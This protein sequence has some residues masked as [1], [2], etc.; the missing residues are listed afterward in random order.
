MTNHPDNDRAPEREGRSTVDYRIDELARASGVTVRNIRYYQDRGILPPPRRDGRVGIYDDAHLARL[1]LITRLLERNYTAANITELLAAWERGRDLSDVLGLERAVSGN[2]DTEVPGLLTHTELRVLLG[3]DPAPLP[4]QPRPAAD[5]RGTD[6]SGEV[7]GID[8][9]EEVIAQAVRRGLVDPTSPKAGLGADYRVPSPRLLHA[10]EGLVAAGA[11][12]EAAV[13]LV[14]RMNA[15]LDDAVHNF[16][17][18]VAAGVLAG[19]EQD[20]M[21]ASSEI[22]DFTELLHRL[23]PLTTSAA[24]AALSASL[25]RHLDEVIGQYVARVMPSVHAAEHPDDRAC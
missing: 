4:G 20:W 22:P 12:P 23:K 14:G 17:A 2:L 21:P 19:R 18:A 16:M 1:R 25:A 7:D 3:T 15:A 5:A 11:P 8:A 10:V 9:T 13:A 6:E 24:E